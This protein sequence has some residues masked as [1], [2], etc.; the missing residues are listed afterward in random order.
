MGYN[1]RMYIIVGLGN[2]GEEYRATRHNVGFRVVEHFVREHGMPDFVKSGMYNTLLSERPG[3]SALLPL[4][5]MNK[6]GGAVAKYLKEKHGTPERLMVIHDE[7]DLPL[8]SIRIS[9]GR[10]GGGHNGVQSIIDSIGTQDFVRVRIGVAK[11]GF[12]GGVK[13]PK[14]DKLG[15]FV[16]ATFTKSEEKELPLIF[17]KATA[18]IQ[19]IMET[20]VQTAMSEYN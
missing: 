14:G 7:V 12:F 4:T 15:N 10:G 18:A 19:S 2:P 5:F 17:E 16:L 6:S 3:I 1:A 11:T 13:R 8:G 9:V 20:G